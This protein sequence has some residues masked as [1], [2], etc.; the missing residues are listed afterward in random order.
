[1]RFYLLVLL[2][3]I[4]I[5]SG[6][7]FDY[8]GFTF[9]LFRNHHKALRSVVEESF[10]ISIIIFTTVYFFSTAF[11]LPL[12]TAL[13]LIGGYLFNIFYGFIAVIIGATLGALTLFVIVRS[14]SMKTSHRNYEKSEIFL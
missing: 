5:L 14:E 2:I 3:G 10:L 1:M 11:S 13:T 4:I 6:I 9:D 7:F 12:G 8:F